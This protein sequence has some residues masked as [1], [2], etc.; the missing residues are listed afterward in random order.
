M[1]KKFED[2]LNRPFVRSTE[3]QSHNCAHSGCDRVGLHRAPDTSKPLGKSYIWLC[4]E[5]AEAFNKAW[6]YYKG[7]SED[8]M[9]SELRR[10]M[11]GERPTRSYRLFAQDKSMAAKR[12]RAQAD[13]QSWA[14]RMGGRQA[15]FHFFDGLDSENLEDGGGVIDR[16]RFVKQVQIDGQWLVL[17]EDL[18]QAL[19]VLQLQTPIAMGEIRTQYRALVKQYHPD[20]RDPDHTEAELVEKLKT[21]T[22]AY[23]HIRKAVAGSVVG[24]ADD[25]P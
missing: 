9:E 10:S 23:Q 7:Y 18:K 24:M 13:F 3:V 4:R 25:I 22:I 14:E 21:I 5:H 8:Q 17:T 2:V 11:V 20:M 15:F 1:V 6:D 16:S 12:M 19:L